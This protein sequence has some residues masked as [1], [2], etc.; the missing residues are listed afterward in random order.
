MSLHNSKQY[1][2]SKSPF[3][4]PFPL[5]QFLEER[6]LGIQGNHLVFQNHNIDE[7][8]E[9]YMDMSKIRSIDLSS[10]RLRSLKGV[11]Q[12]SDLRNLNVS[13]NQ[14]SDVSELFYLKELQNLQILNLNNNPVVQQQNYKLTLMTILPNLQVLDSKKLSQ[15]D[16]EENT[17]QVKFMNSQLNLLYENY[18]KMV[19]L[20]SIIQ[21]LLTHK[22]YIFTFEPNVMNPPFNLQKFRKIFSYGDT[23]D[24]KVQQEIKTNLLADVQTIQNEILKTQKI[25]EAFAEM[26]RRQIEKI[27]QLENTVLQRVKEYKYNCL[28]IEIF[29]KLNKNNTKI[30]SLKK[31]INFTRQEQK[32]EAVVVNKRGKVQKNQKDQQNIY[33]EDSYS[34]QSNQNKNEQAQF[35]QD[36]QTEESLRGSFQ[37]QTFTERDLKRL[38]NINRDKS[39]SNMSEM[40]V[41]NMSEQEKELLIEKLAGSLKKY[42]GKS[43]EFEK[44]YEKALLQSSNDQEMLR[45]K[46]E[47]LNCIM[48]L[49]QQIKQKLEDYGVQNIDECF[50]TLQA[51]LEQIK[52]FRYVLEQQEIEE[53]NTQKAEYFSNLRLMQR[54]LGQLYFQTKKHKMVKTV[55]EK[56]NNYRNL[57]I[58]KLYLSHWKQYHV[59]SKIRKTKSEDMLQK[60]YVGCF[61]A[62]KFNAARAKAI[63]QYKQKFEKGLAEKA[64]RSLFKFLVSKKREKQDE[65][66]AGEKYSLFLLKK[67]FQSIFYN[68]LQHSNKRDLFYEQKMQIAEDFYT[69][70][71]QIKVLSRFRDVCEN[72]KYNKKKVIAMTQRIQ[73]AMLKYNFR[74]FKLENIKMKKLTSRADKFLGRRQKY[75][76]REAFNAWKV[77][78]RNYQNEKQQVNLQVQRFQLQSVFNVFKRAYL[79]S[80]QQTANI[81]NYLRRKDLLLYSQ[82]FAI[83]KKFSKQQVKVKQ[84]A[85]NYLIKKQQQSLKQSIQCMKIHTQLTKEKKILDKKVKKII[86]TRVIQNLRQMQY[87][88]I[89]LK[90]KLKNV[91]KIQNSQKVFLMKQ[92]LQ[93]WNK[94][95]K[96][97][98]KLENA[99]KFYQKY[100]FQKQAYQFISNLL[101][102]GNKLKKQLNSQLDEKNIQIIKENQYLNEQLIEQQK[103]IY[104]INEEFQQQVVKNEQLAKY[105]LEK[106]V[107][108]Q[109][110]IK[111]NND[112]KEINIQLT[113]V[114]EKREENN[115]NFESNLNII[116][117][118]YEQ[119]I[120]SLKNVQ[121]QFERERDQ[122]NCNIQNLNIELSAKIEEINEFK[123]ITAAKNEDFYQEITQLKKKILA[124]DKII[125]EYEE[126]TKSLAN[127][128]KEVESLN[129]HLNVRAESLQERIQNLQKESAMQ[130]SSLEKQLEFANRE[131]SNLIAQNTS[132]M[133]QNKTFQAEL[134]QLNQ[135]L[136]KEE[137]KV[138]LLREQDYDKTSQ[139]I[140]LAKNINSPSRKQATSPSR[141]NGKLKTLPEDSLIDERV[142]NTSHSRI[143]MLIQQKTDRHLFNLPITQENVIQ[144]SNNNSMS[145]F[146]SHKIP[147]MNQ[148]QHN[149]IKKEVSPLKEYLTDMKFRASVFIKTI[150]MDERNKKSISNS[151]QKSCVSPQKTSSPQQY[152][153][154]RN[155]LN[156]TQTSVIKDE[157][158]RRLNNLDYKFNED[159]KKFQTQQ[160]Q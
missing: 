23:L 58:L 109:Q 43:K 8:D 56:S 77:D 157:I 39:D 101:Q 63:K 89:L 137:F 98:K 141:Y 114:A 28:D 97:D 126:M 46:E 1:I 40:N 47:E 65:I 116:E 68:H 67:G 25:E 51:Q 9:L 36:Y 69:Q 81:Q 14:I 3:K 131:R 18:L 26:E 57:K 124:Q 15:S 113:E 30:Q 19:E 59:F 87:N 159:I 105:N 144:N 27:Q 150:D 82:Y 153:I 146:F 91:L 11:Q 35:Q 17:R 133:N 16:V 136:K 44:Q 83:I 50:Q 92:A 45:K 76:L 94:E 147:Q 110:L 10:N 158:Q 118:G 107:L 138:S 7:I 108:I 22:E 74:E 72:Q 6:H 62:L 21:R 125:T 90:Q 127:T 100:Q 117:D 129:V 42:I 80:C 123:N 88:K 119:K 152:K 48:E 64:F 60:I 49:Q 148:T 66:V 13:N 71:I 95:A 154:Q 122:L 142:L 140:Q 130:V 139:F 79:L 106:D 160:Q 29:H 70:Q 155:I 143:N 99:L 86:F 73:W 84:F 96:R 134:N 121:I 156:Q 104:L 75:W 145:Q 151:P 52:E 112:L 41:K 2:S 20:Q 61:F 102:N 135:N 132:L 78:F 85:K 53:Q 5:S 34:S 24:E 54:S 12:F 128:N 32:Q 33:V 120:R 149:S 111:Q 4:G 115:Q 31:F 55:I 93:K 103:Q 37:N 38:A